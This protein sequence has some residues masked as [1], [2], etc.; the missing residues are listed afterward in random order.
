MEDNLF[1]QIL[2]GQNDI[3]PQM[4][5]LAEDIVSEEAQL[6]ELNQVEIIEEEIPIP[7]I[8]NGGNDRSNFKIFLS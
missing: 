6:P 4:I 5:N 8:K 1:N 3:L 7:G 2:Y